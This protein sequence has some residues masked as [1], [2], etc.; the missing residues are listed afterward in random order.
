MS[1]RPY[2]GEYLVNPVAVH[3]GLN[4]CSHNCFYCYANLN[5]PDR[6]ADYNKVKNVAMAIANNKQL[7][8]LA[9]N[10]LQAGHP[11][12]VSNDSD[13]FAQS[14]YSQFSSIFDMFNDLD[15]RFCF[16]TRGG[17]NSKKVLAKSKPTMVYISFTSDNNEIIKKAE[18]G[19]PSFESRKDLALTAKALGHHVV[20]GLNPYQSEWWNDVYGFVDWL[21]ENDLKHVWF[22]VMH[23][24]H[25][26]KPKI[27]AK[28]QER[29]AD[30]IAKASKKFKIADETEL[31]L[32]EMAQRG[33][34]VFH[35]AVSEQGG[36]WEAYFELG[37]PFF[38]TLD[39]FF[40]SLRQEGERIAFTFNA[41]DEWANAHPDWTGSGFSDYLASI[42]RSLRDV[43]YPSRANS[44]TEVHETLW[45]IADFPTRLRHDDLFIATEDGDILVDDDNRPILIYQSGIDDPSIGFLEIGTCNTIIGV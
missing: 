40:T 5:N 20:I 36:F 15:V 31:L 34:N 35:G 13:P 39:D 42:G 24:S 22:G 27:K 43:G 8:N 25:L 29:F 4:Y 16:Q 19:A 10:L 7:K 11:I 41:F 37:F 17:Q 2:T 30:V 23:L 3:L 21:T 32:S 6:R 38:P 33:I 44:F 28:Q 14:N 45:R 18:A 26:Q 1:I 9:V 12:M